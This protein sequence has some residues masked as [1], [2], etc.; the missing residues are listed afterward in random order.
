MHEAG[1]PRIGPPARWNVESVD[2]SGQIGS[3][4]VNNCDVEFFGPDSHNGLDH[5]QRGRPIR[6][7]VDL[8]DEPL[9]PTSKRIDV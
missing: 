4:V 9:K 6:Q 5:R 8:A 2:D 1:Q 3:V 7:L